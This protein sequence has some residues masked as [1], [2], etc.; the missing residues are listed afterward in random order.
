MTTAALLPRCTTRGCPWRFT[1]G[2]PDRP[3]PAC[4]DDRTAPL[5]DR[6]AIYGVMTA[7]PGE[8]DGESEAT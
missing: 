8:R 2:G 6:A 4:R 5:V 7:A 3:C 1:T